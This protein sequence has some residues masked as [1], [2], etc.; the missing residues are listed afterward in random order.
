M[1]QLCRAVY[2]HHFGVQREGLVQTGR[3]SQQALVHKQET[4][5]RWQLREL[6]AY[7]R[8]SITTSC[9]LCLMHTRTELQVLQPANG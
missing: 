1:S 9:H 8:G 6:I 5:Q 2:K 3:Q 7:N 4:A